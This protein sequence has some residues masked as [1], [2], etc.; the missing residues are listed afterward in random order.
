MQERVDKIRQ[1]L[2]DKKAD[3]FCF[4]DFQG[5]DYFADGVVLCTSLNERHAAA[6]MDEL[7]NE[8]KPEEQFLNT[9]DRSS[10]WMIA[11]LGDIIVHVMDR[12]LRSIYDLETFFKDLGKKQKAALEAQNAKN[13]TN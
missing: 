8:L 12:E 9:D 6:L 4:F 10:N 7:K 11:D 5:T 2:E 1:V 3:D 13:T